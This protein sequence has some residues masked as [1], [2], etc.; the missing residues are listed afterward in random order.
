MEFNGE[1]V[2]NYITYP[3]D[4]AD[5][6]VVYS[7]GANRYVNLPAGNWTQVLNSTGASNVTGLSSAV[8]VEGTSVTVFAKAH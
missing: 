5:L 1:L 3:T 7:S 2:T 6:F 8:M 4:N